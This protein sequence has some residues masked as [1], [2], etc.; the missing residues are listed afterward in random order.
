MKTC[1]VNGC[2]NKYYARECCQKHYMQLYLYGKILKRTRHNLNEYID[3]GDYYEIVLYNREHK[4]VAK[5]LIDKEEYIKVK[6]YKWHYKD[7][8][9]TNSNGSILKLHQLILGKK[10]GFDIDHIDH[11][12]TDNRKH[13]LRHCTRSQ[14]LMNRKSKGYF[15]DKRRNKWLAQIKINNKN[16]YLGLFKIKQEAINARRKAEKKYFGEFAFKAK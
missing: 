16:I 11:C 2:H 5:A 6:N 3:K 1:K 8:V 14:N 13:N 10:E 15:W 9:K 12:K 7:Y 4:A